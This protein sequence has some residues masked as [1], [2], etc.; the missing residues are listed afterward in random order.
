MIVSGYCPDAG[1][2]WLSKETECNLGFTPL[3]RSL[4]R[5]IAIITRSDPASAWAARHRTELV[6]VNNRHQFAAAGR[7]DHD[8]LTDHIAAFCHSRRTD[9]PKT[10]PRDSRKHEN[11]DG[12]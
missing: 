10:N 5:W 1:L 3:K 12:E 7:F 8:R 11:Q 2:A 6:H 4:R 9:H